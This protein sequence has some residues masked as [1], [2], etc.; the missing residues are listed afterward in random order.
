[1]SSIQVLLF[2][3]FYLWSHRPRNAFFTQ[4][5]IVVGRG[6]GW[7]SNV[8]AFSMLLVKKIVGIDKKNQELSVGFFPK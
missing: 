1:M 8:F 7:V 2:V 4:C 6:N 3:Q 5:F